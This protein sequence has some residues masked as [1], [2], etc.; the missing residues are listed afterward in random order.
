MS[1][2]QN[3]PA[4]IKL[5]EYAK[6]KSSITYDE[7]SDF[8]PD[9]IMGTEKMGEVISLLEKNNIRMED[10]ADAI[11]AADARPKP[12][13]AQKRLIYNEKDSAIDDPIRLY[14]REIGKE[15]LLT[16]E[17]EVTLSKR[18]E[19]GGQIIKDVVRTSPLIIS[20]FY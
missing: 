20:E 3:D 4:V 19:E 15:N 7:V 18:M 6:A 9:T 1:D 11:A 16:A 8:L 5:L 2:L 13:K 14:L 12:E 10:E 17:Q